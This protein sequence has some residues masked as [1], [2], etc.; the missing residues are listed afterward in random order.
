MNFTKHYIGYF[1]KRTVNVASATIETVIEKSDCLNYLKW[2]M[3]I[4]VQ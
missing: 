4:D 1:W 2:N 3:Q